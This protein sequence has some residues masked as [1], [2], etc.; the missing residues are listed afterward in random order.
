MAIAFAKAKFYRPAGPVSI[1]SR[2]REAPWSPH[3]EHY[4]MQDITIC[5]IL[6]YAGYYHMQDITICRIWP[7]AGYH[8]TTCRTLIRTMLWHLDYRQLKQPCKGAGI[9]IGPKKASQ[10]YRIRVLPSWAN[11]HQN[12]LIYNNPNGISFSS[13]ISAILV[14]FLEQSEWNSGRLPVSYR[15]VGMISAMEVLSV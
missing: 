5:R 2:P 8:S 3:V 13:S 6:P 14:T 10:W 1:R 7:Q 9:E 15:T 11:L 4:H 12:P